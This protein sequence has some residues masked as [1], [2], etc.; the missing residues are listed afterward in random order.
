M[1]LLL[2][3]LYKNNNLANSAQGEEE[4]ESMREEELRAG[5]PLL[6]SQRSLHAGQLH[7]CLTH[8]PDLERPIASCSLGLRLDLILIVGVWAFSHLLSKSN[9][10]TPSSCLDGN[11]CNFNLGG[12]WQRIPL[13]HYHSCPS[14]TIIQP[15]LCKIT[16]TP[17][18]RNKINHCA[19]QSK[20][21]WDRTLSAAVKMKM[22][23]DLFPKIILAFSSR[24]NNFKEIHHTLLR[25]KM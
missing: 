15:P 4:M 22:D 21:A 24:M 6:R 5:S 17:R 19:A 2:L 12:S 20:P 14:Y 7:V 18:P 25:G 16:L 9:P 23:V 10:K 3:F 11:I 8:R 1:L 13:P